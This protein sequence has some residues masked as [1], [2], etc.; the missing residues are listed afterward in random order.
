M[1]AAAIYGNPAT[2]R[3]YCGTQFALGGAWIEPTY[4]LTVGAPGLPAIGVFPFADAKS[5]AQGIA[6]PNI[7]ITQ[8]LIDGVCPSRLGSA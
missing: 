2:M 1:G 7:G 5:D 4:N 8:D 6:A 3:Q